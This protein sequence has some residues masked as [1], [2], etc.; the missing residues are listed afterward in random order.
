MNQLAAD[1]LPGWCKKKKS[2]LLWVLAQFFS[3]LLQCSRVVEAIKYD[4]INCFHWFLY[5]VSQKCSEF[6]YAFNADW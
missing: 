6:C 3:T 2:W 5:Y 4:Q 1:I